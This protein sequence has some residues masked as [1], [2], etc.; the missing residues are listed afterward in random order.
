[1]KTLTWL[2]A[3]TLAFT[4]LFP[5]CGGS[6]N[7]GGGGG[8][9]SAPSAPTG[10]TATAGNQ[11]VALTWMASATATSYNVKRATVSGGPYTNV[12]SGTAVSFTDSSLA[13]GT[14]YFYVV[15]AVNSSGESAN[16]AEASA[17]PTGA[18]SW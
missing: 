4:L 14:K 11:Q 5:S 10:L 17:T 16:S 9:G 18:C 6:N 8:G 1:M 13:N 7:N 12:S 2:T 15:S 3:P